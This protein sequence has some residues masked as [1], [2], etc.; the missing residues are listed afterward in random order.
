MTRT[1]YLRVYQPLSSFPVSEREAWQE[2]AEDDDA[3][4]LV[5]QKRWLIHASLP[6]SALTAEAERAYIRRIDGELFVCPRRTRLRMLAGLLA[7]R[8]SL[9]DEVAEA[10]VSGQEA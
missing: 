3:G 2:V 6:G 5:T 1:A 4:E 7:F 10:F 8:G 9:P